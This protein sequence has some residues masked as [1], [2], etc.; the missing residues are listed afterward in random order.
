MWREKT[1]HSPDRCSPGLGR[2]Q[3][4]RDGGVSLIE[5]RVRVVLR[6][7][8]GCSRTKQHFHCAPATAFGSDGN[9]VLTFHKW[10]IK[11]LLSV[12]TRIIKK[13]LKYLFTLFPFQ[14]NRNRTI[15]KTALKIP[16]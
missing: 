11:I 9:T 8:R 10:N 14:L 2:F 4:D 5:G 1:K 16:S 6:H 13:L 12:M 15:F 7:G 3:H